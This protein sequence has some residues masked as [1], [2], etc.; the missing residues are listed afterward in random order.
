MR[1]KRLMQLYIG[2]A[3]PTHHSNSG[4]AYC[5]A[6]DDVGGPMSE[7]RCIV[8]VHLP[9]VPNRN[10]MAPEGPALII[11]PSGILQ[12]RVLTA[13]ELALFASFGAG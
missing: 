10:Q 4:A 1:H 2:L 5:D 12:T 9:H 8:S 3:P 6:A 13:E 11:G 7:A